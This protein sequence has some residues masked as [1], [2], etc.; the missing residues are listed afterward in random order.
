MI[1]GKHIGGKIGMGGLTLGA[2]GLVAVALPVEAEAQEQNFT[3]DAERGAYHGASHESDTYIT[4]WWDPEGD[5]LESRSYFKF[6][7]D[8]EG[9]TATE[10]TLRINTGDFWLFADGPWSLQLSS[11][12]DSVSNLGNDDQ[13]IFADLGSGPELADAV[14][15]DSSGEGSVWEIDLNQAALAEINASGGEWAIGGAL[16]GLSS[17][18]GTYEVIFDGTR[19]MDADAVQL[20]VTAIPEPTTAGL[21]AGMLGLLGMR[22]RNRR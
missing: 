15:V 13:D 9:L 22:R 11:V 6:N 17:D 4:G 21:M 2:L 19:D 8:L 18:S 10:A 5:W 16:T 12:T 20:D 3:F 7:V 14:S 1:A